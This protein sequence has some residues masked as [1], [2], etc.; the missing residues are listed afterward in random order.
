M[1]SFSTFLAQFG[2]LISFDFY[3]HFF[4]RLL[5]IKQRMEQKIVEEGGGRSGKIGKTC[6]VWKEI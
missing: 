4:R 6:I 3:H 5:G 2:I 1:F